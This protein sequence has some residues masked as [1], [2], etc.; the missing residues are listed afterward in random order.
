MVARAAALG[1]VAAGALLLAGCGS[2]HKPATFSGEMNA[3]CS[4]SKRQ[5]RL[6]GHRWA[7]EEQQYL[8]KLRALTPLRTEQAIYARFL[9]T[10]Q[11]VINGFSSN[12][13]GAS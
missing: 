10:F 3:I 1:T 8:T 5:T 9:G 12:N 4:P 7:A 11:I 6:G 2:T 13:P